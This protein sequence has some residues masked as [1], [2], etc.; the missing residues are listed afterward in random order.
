[1]IGAFR[2]APMFELVIFCVFALAISYWVALWLMDRHD[3]VLHGDFVHPEHGAEP[4]PPPAL[5]FPKRPPS[6]KAAPA[7]TPQ[8]REESFEMLQ[9]LLAAIERDLKD[10]S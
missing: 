3:D 9:A 4:P 5:P 1:M 8:S 2:R 6:R 7:A 10:A